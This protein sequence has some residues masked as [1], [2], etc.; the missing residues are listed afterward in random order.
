MENKNN[1]MDNDSVDLLQIKIERAKAELS[2]DTLNAINAVDW[3]TAILKM[4]EK[5][6]YSFEQLGALETE[7]EL[8]LC[9][10]LNPKDYPK[11]LENRMGVSKARAMELVQEMNNEV[12]NKIKEEL[13]KNTERKSIFAAKNPVRE[14]PIQNGLITP[15]PIENKEEKLNT[16]AFGE[17][18]IEIINEKEKKETLPVPEKLEIIGK[19]QPSILTQ[20]FSGPVSI[21]STK[22]E[23]TLPNLSG[24]S[25]PTPP[26]VEA[27]KPAVDPYREIPE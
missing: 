24:S 11:E 14:T 5:N 4:R 17:H 18:G 7:T 1:N 27:T 2:N 22:T 19:V 9:G 21:P 12:F 16:Q 10:L 3:K 26:K 13:I 8:V 20:K 23:H 15:K 6:G 25:I